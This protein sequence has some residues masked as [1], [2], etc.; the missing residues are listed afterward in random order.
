MLQ[1]LQSELETGGSGAGISYY[2]TIAECSRKAALAKD[3]ERY[4][5][6][7]TTG[8]DVGTI[9]HKLLEYYHGKREK[10]I[11]ILTSDIALQEASDEAG[12]LFNA[13]TQAHTVDFF[14]EVL[15]TERF[16]PT[17]AEVVAVEAAVG[18]KPFTGRIDLVAVVRLADVERLQKVPGLEELTAPG[19]YLVDHKF[20]GKRDSNAL[21]I[22]NNSPQFTAYMAC[23]NAI[24]DDAGAPHCQGMIANVIVGNKTP[25]FEKYLVK[26]PAAS[27]I[28]ALRTWLAWCKQRENDNQPNWISCFNY[29]RPC[30][31]MLSGRC[32]KE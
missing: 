6:A 2:S 28:V 9:G 17:E 18:I 27:Q 23:Y 4:Y 13:Y 32:T 25:V 3:A 10:E 15:Q 21:L 14:G 20:K 7:T 8:R 12:R 11:A 26:P 30:E 29:H 1:I 19:I 16:F 22:Y 5:N 24:A 31:H